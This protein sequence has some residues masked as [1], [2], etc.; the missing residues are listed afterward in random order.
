[1]KNARVSGVLFLTLCIIGTGCKSAPGPNNHSKDPLEPDWVMDPSMASAW[2]PGPYIFGIGISDK[3][4]QND[5]VAR[6]QAEANARL[7]LARRL[8]EFAS[9]KIIQVS[10][11][12]TGYSQPISSS[13]IQIITRNQAAEFIHNCPIVKYWRSNM[14][15]EYFVLARLRYTPVMLRMRDEVNRAIAKALT[16]KSRIKKVMEAYDNEFGIDAYPNGE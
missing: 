5:L 3:R 12:Q 13:Q 8:C 7:D 15:N 1:M 14:T 2:Y 6:K 4:V 16:D 9:S 10:N 11:D